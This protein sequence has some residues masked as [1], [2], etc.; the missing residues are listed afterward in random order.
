VP[1]ELDLA[2]ALRLLRERHGVPL[3]L[4]RHVGSEAFVLAADESSA[5]RTF[6]LGGMVEHLAGKFSWVEA[7]PDD[8]HTARLRLRNVDALPER[9]EEVVAEIGRSRALLEG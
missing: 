9:L 8:D 3:A 7:L 5:G 1:A 6:D 4:A 2:L